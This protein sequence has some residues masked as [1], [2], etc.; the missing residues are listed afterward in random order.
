[1]PQ[2]PLKRQVVKVTELPR[3]TAPNFVEIY[4]N[5]AG[6]SSTFQD[7]RIIFGQIIFGMDDKNTIEDRASITMSWEHALALRNLLDRLITKYEE[8]NGKIRVQVEPGTAA[9]PPMQ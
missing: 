5:N 1:M 9:L 7:L 8:E 6:S 3:S 4:A 2:E